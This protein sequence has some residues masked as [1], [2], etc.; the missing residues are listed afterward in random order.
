MINIFK[1][2]KSVSISI[3]QFFDKVNIGT[4]NFKK[5]NVYLSGVAKNLEYKCD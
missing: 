3:D 1:R 4:L 5:G 2:S